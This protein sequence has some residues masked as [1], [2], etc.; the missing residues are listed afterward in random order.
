MDKI[1]AI[2]IEAEFQIESKW[3]PFGHFVNLRFIDVTP[4]KPKLHNAIE[5]LKKNDDLQIIDY[6]Y[7]EIPITETTSIKYFDITKH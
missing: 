4:N 1:D 5:E 3:Q 2:I 6:H 7:K